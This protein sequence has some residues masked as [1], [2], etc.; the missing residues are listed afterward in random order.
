MKRSND[1]PESHFDEMIIGSADKVPLQDVS[2]DMCIESRS[3]KYP[4]PCCG[5][6]TLPVD[7]SEAIA[8]ICPVCFRE[9]DVFTTRDD[10][11]S[12]EN[13]GMTLNEARAEFKRIGAKEEFLKHVRKPYPEERIKNQ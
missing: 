3:A 1:L 11:P 7:K 8:Y 4:C 2:K 5:C 13:H 9:N 12:D 10:E 6:Y